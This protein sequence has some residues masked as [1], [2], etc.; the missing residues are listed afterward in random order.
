M[1]EGSFYGSDGYTQ[2]TVLVS[3]L[4]YLERIRQF[5]ERAAR[6]V[7]AGAPPPTTGQPK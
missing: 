1:R 5:Y 4:I 6:L 7:S 2:V 3:E